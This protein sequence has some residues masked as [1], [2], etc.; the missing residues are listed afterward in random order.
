MTDDWM[1]ANLRLHHS[2][3]SEIKDSVYFAMVDLR[4]F[5]QE[6]SLHGHSRARRVVIPG[7]VDWIKTVPDEKLKKSFLSSVKK[8]A[9]ASKPGDR[10]ILYIVSHSIKLNKETRESGK[11]GHVHLGNKA[12]LQPEDIYYIALKSAGNTTIIVDACFSGLWSDALRF[13]PTGKKGQ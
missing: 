13:L 10:L 1:F 8:A 4:P 2:L 3:M 9:K 11:A 6:T 5:E 12:L 7:G